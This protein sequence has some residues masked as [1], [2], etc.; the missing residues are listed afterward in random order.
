MI[1]STFFALNA[2]TA[3][4][5]A[6]YVFPVPAGPIPK[7]TGFFSI[8]STYFFCP[9]VLHLI[10]FPVA[11]TATTPSNSASA[12]SVS[13]AFAVSMQYKIC[14]SSTA[15]PFFAADNAAAS[16]F[17][18][19]T[20]ASFSPEMRKESPSTKISTPSSRE[21]VVRFSS[22]A[23]IISYNLSAESTAKFKTT[24]FSSSIYSTELCP[25]GFLFCVAAR[26]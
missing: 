11:V 17:S 14:L 13:P 26:G 4:A 5:T 10:F 16:A 22:Y 2:A 23:P 6:R 7:T 19:N 1:L 20:A 24:F 3:F 25:A 15:P 18:H 12:S 8:A 9:I 21:S